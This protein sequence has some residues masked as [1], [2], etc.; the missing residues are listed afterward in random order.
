MFR[1]ACAGFGV[2]VLAGCAGSPSAPEHTEAEHAAAPA[3]QVEA[4]AEPVSE[5][6]AEA[7]VS[8]F[9]GKWSLNPTSLWITVWDVV[10]GHEGAENIPEDQ[11]KAMGDKV[12]EIVEGMSV[13][14]TIAPGGGVDIY[15]KMGE[16]VI[17]G[18]GSW[19]AIEDNKIEIL[20]PTGDGVGQ[21]TTYA[22]FRDGVFTLIDPTAQDGFAEMLY[23]RVHE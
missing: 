8:P 17:T 2:M 16:N 6:E 13:V 9:V 19:K 14:L 1:F 20:L 22:E 10:Y 12:D 15:T 11:A 23:D 3:A 18:V 7:E 5:V 21:A 4:P